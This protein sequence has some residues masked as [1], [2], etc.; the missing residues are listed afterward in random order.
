MQLN[1]MAIIK[2]TTKN[3]IWFYFNINNILLYPATIPSGEVL[4]Q[5]IPCVICGGLGW[6]LFCVQPTPSRHGSGDNVVLIVET[7][8]RLAT[9]VL[10]S[11]SLQSMRQGWTWRYFEN[12]RSYLS[13]RFV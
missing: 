2:I 1:N 9:A 3:N 12:G 7:Q 5:L 11:R 10:C 4:L 13:S 8:Q 6:L